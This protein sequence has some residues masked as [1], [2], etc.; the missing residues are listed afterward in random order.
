MID[1][2]KYYHISSDSFS[3]L[4]N[5]I[6]LHLKNSKLKKIFLCRISKS[7]FLIFSDYMHNFWISNLSACVWF[8]RSCIF[9]SSR[10]FNGKHDRKKNH[11]FQVFIYKNSDN[12]FFWTDITGK[13][14]MH[15]CFFSR[16]CGEIRLLFQISRVM[17]K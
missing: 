1:T 9:Y 6:W 7:D 14:W 11:L 4:C 8:N 2:K 12:I 3:D 16:K 13:W 10:D 5:E 15:M 17:K